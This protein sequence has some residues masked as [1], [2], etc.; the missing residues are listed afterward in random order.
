MTLR[1]L[2]NHT[3]GI[4]GDVFTDTGRGDDCLERYV[5]LLG[6][7]T[8]NHPLGATWSYCN[9]GFSVLGRVIEKLTGKTW[10]E[11]LRERLFTPLQLQHAVTLPEEA[12]LH[13]A[14]VGHVTQD[15]V[16]SVAPIW[17]LPR[18]IGPAGLVTANVAGVLAFARLHL[19]GG[20]GPDGTRVLSEESAIAM[21]DHQAD[22]P[23]KYSLGDSWGL[24]W[25]RFGWDGQRLYGHDGNTIGQAAFLRVLPGAGLAVAML[26]NN[27]GSRDLYEDLYRE[28]FAEL[29][30]VEMP[31]PLTPPQPP[32]EDPAGAIAPYVARYERAGVTMQVF[33]GD[34]GPMLR[35]TVTGPL[36]EM[37]PEPVTEYALVPYGPALVP[38]QAAGGGDLVPGHLLRTADRRAIPPLRCARHPAGGLMKV[39]ST[40]TADTD[41]DQAVQVADTA[42]LAAGVTVR[43]ISDLT[44]LTE[45]VVLYAGIWGRD[46][47]PPITLELLR[48]FTKAGNYVG[49]AFSGGR[50]TGACVGFFHA[51]SDDALH[52]HIAG[53][54]R[55][56]LD[57]HIGFALKLH[58]RAWAMLH[59]VSEIAWTFD[60]L[61]S[62]NAYFNLAK[63]AARPVEYLPNFYGAMPDAINGLDDSD[64]LLISWR[65]RDP[66]V[67]AACAGSPTPALVDD[68]LAAGAVVGLGIDSDG[69]PE[70]GRLRQ[71]DRAG[72][73]TP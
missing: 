35:T 60:P 58:Q 52:S 25:I 73:R 21:A 65:L 31:W 28:I 1:H 12:L 71:D 13:A 32:L 34:D 49:G 47:N 64:R 51:P 5:E 61:V 26:T 4:D 67:K 9:A 10:D 54:S 55:D 23:D 41:L 37:V 62:R 48:A 16:K 68:E 33:V 3:S 18:S 11:A 57:R 6:E 46:A 39:T 29:A 36:A 20:V 59:G 40:G 30:G 53:V 17:Q 15:G 70:P 45:V 44:E 50:L 72:R 66:R 22:L 8:Q 14:A 27:D 69:G 2:L 43:E 24:G 63:L 38:D 42:A 19:T 56:A 7:Q